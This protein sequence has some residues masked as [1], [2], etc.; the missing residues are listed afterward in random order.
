MKGVSSNQPVRIS[1]IMLLM[2][3]GALGACQSLSLLP[4]NSEGNDAR[5]VTVLS[6]QEVSAAIRQMHPLM[7][8]IPPIP[9]PEALAVHPGDHV[10]DALA[11]LNAVN[12]FA[13]SHWPAAAAKPAYVN[14]STGGWVE[15][16]SGTNP[17]VV[18]YT[19]QDGDLT[20]TITHVLGL[21]GNWLW[22]MTWDGCDGEHRYDDF[23]VEWWMLTTDG[24]LMKHDVFQ[25]LDSPPCDSATG[26]HDSTPLV[27]WMFEVLDNGTLYTLWDEVR[28]VT[29][30]YTV[31]QYGYSVRFS[32]FAPFTQDV[33]TSYPDGRLV[34]EGY[35]RRLSDDLLYKWYRG[36]WTADHRY[37]WTMYREDETVLNC[38]GDMGCPDCGP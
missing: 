28:L 17:V 13:S 12:G 26:C 16:S 21:P 38:G 5:T 24:K 2:G 20:T 7:N 8:D 29:R 33:C 36:I 10:Q 6:D 37:C 15:Q 14:K 9:I 27:T 30:R 11:R 3:L 22:W 4:L 23:M 18:T 25:C 31:I 32:G 35:M 1:T 19:R 34:F